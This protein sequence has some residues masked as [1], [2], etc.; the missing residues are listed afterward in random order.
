M[1]FHKC[2]E[3]FD[4]PISNEILNKTISMWTSS[5]YAYM[6]FPVHFNSLQHGSWI[7]RMRHW[8]ECNKTTDGTGGFGI[9]VSFIL[10][11][12]SITRKRT[13]QVVVLF[14]TLTINSIT[15]LSLKSHISKLHYG[16]QQTSNDEVKYPG[17]WRSLLIS[18]LRYR[19]WPRKKGKY[20]GRS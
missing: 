7:W 13:I 5:R 11:Q 17:V 20:S 9:F 2:L 19:E 16:L 15:D 6:K 1:I 14:S 3:L 8:K 4:R 18:M 10:L 12:S